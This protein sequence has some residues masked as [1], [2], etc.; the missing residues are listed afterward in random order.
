[1]GL[2]NFCVLPFGLCNAPGT[3]ERIMDNMLTGMLGTQC[4]AY[5]D[6]VVVFGKTFQECNQRLQRVLR[7][8]AEAGLKLKTNKCKLFRR[9]VK[10]LGH[11]VSAKG[12]STDPTK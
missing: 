2:F 4:M 6:D 7:R 10:F 3:F 12:I 9:Q 8:I 5:L 1:M 11:V